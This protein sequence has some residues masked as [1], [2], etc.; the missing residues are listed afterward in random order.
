MLKVTAN[1][2]ACKAALLPAIEDLE[3][4]AKEFAAKNYTDAIGQFAL[5]LDVF[6]KATCSDAC[7]LKVVADATGDLGPQVKAA[8]VKA[9]GEWHHTRRSQLAAPK[10]TSTST[11]TP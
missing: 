1:D 11:A 8:V 7:E 6:A 5:G 3:F 4:G 2:V 10:L 9:G